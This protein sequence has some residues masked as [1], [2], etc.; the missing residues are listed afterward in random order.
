LQLPLVNRQVIHRTDQWPSF[1]W[2]KNRN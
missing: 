2:K 1:V